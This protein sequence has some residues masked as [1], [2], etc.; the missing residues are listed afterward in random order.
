MI[1]RSKRSPRL[2]S[3][4][5]ESQPKANTI[6]QLLGI[7]IEQEIQ[8]FRKRNRRGK[9]RASYSSDYRDPLLQFPLVIAHASGLISPVATGYYTEPVEESGFDVDGG[10]ELALVC[11]V[12]N[13]KLP[14]VANYTTLLCAYKL[15]KKKKET[16]SELL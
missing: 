13:Q 12:P 2:S 5:A 4:F 14:K 9:G 6:K 11:L 1:P 16:K 7:S 8:K 3:P 15:Q 10:C